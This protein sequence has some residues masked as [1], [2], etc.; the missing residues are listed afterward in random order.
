MNGSVSECLRER[1]TYRDAVQK[2]IHVAKPRLVGWLVGHNFAK[3]REISPSDYFSELLFLN[4]LY[5]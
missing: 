1:M 5:I 4:R 3:G 2:K